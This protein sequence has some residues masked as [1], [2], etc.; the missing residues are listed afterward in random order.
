MWH[1]RGHSRR[2]ARAQPHAMK[3]ANNKEF[4]HGDHPTLVGGAR[5]HQLSTTQV[6]WAD[7]SPA[8]TALHTNRRNRPSHDLCKGPRSAPESPLLGLLAVASD[9]RAHTIPHLNESGLPHA[10][11]QARFGR[12]NQLSQRTQPRPRPQQQAHRPKHYTLPDT[13]RPTQGTQGTRNE[14]K[15]GLTHSDFKSINRHGR[16]GAS[17]RAPLRQTGLASQMG[18]PTAA[19]RTAHS[20]V[21]TGQHKMTTRARTHAPHAPHALTAP[22]YRAA[23]WDV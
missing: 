22:R 16:R 4:H 1:P 12:H 13:G 2:S 15:T 6:A 20:A 8:S 7:L 14:T 5:R 18:Q 10:Q 17:I 9:S 23:G 3:H 21:G 11:A 19:P